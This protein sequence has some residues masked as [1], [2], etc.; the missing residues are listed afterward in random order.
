MVGIGVVKANPDLEGT[1]VYNLQFS[2]LNYL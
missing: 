2:Q 1:A